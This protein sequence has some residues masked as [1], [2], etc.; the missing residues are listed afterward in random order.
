MNGTT[1]A[2][3]SAKKLMSI[4]ITQLPNKLSYEKNEALDL[5]GIK[6]MATYTD[7]TLEEVTQDCIFS[8]TNGTT[9]ATSTAVTAS[10]TLSGRTRTDTF[11]VSVAVI[12]GIKITGTESA[13]ASIIEYIEEAVGMTPAAM[14]YSTG[15]FSYGSWADAFFMPR[16]CMLKYDGTVD[17]YLDPDDYTKKEDGVAASDIANTAY[18]G[19]AMMEWGQNGKKIWSKIV[20][21]ASGKGASIYISDAQADDGYKALP[22]INNQGVLVD[23]FYTPIFNGSLI[24]NVCRSISGQAP[25]NGET[26]E[27]EISYARANNKDGNILWDTEVLSD[28]QLITYLLLLVGRS[29]ETQLIYGNGHYTG[30]SDASSLLAS[31]T[32]NTKGLFW[33][34]NGTGQGVKV[35]GMEHFWGNQW[36]RY[37]GHINANGT[38]KIKL[39]H[40]PQDGSQAADYNLDGAGYKVVD[41]ATPSGTS[42]GYINEMKFTEDGMFAK[43]ASGSSSTYWCDGLSFNNSQVDYAFRGGTC[44]SDL[45]VGAFCV[46]LYRLASDARWDIGAAPSCKPLA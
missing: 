19:N 28:N 12:Y 22:F 15:K 16:P 44:S 26:A 33:G 11:S 38:Q 34:T 10:Y 8:P 13:P 45:K 39:T 36:R 30:G 32:M 46:D 6:V 25:M 29:T 7:G 1:N 23:H 43:V 27:Q 42:G 3:S 5:T 2:G 35:F 31:G 9:L 40:G 17:Y 4:E 14:N 20:P 37:R 41:G 24:N 18:A 21:D